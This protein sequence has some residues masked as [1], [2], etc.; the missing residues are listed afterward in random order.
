VAAQAAFQSISLTDC[1][2]FFFSAK[3]ATSFMELL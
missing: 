2:G 1:R 3:Y